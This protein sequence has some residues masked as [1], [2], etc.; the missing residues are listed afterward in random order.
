MSARRLL[1]A[2]V[3]VGTL[4][5]AGVLPAP[6][7][8]ACIYNPPLVSPPG[9]TV[10]TT[11]TI[12]GAADPGTTCNSSVILSGFG[13]GTNN[14]VNLFNK[15]QG[16]G[17]TG[18]GLVNDPSGQNEVIVGSFI[19]IQFVNPLPGMRSIQAN[20]VTDGET[21][22]LLGTNTPGSLAGAA[23]VVG[24]QTN[25]QSVI[26]FDPG[27][28]MFFDF[29]TT[30]PSGSNVLLARLDSPEGTVSTPEP[31]SL[32][33]LGAALVG[34]GVIRGRRRSSTSV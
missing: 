19:Q 26:N 22:T 6:S 28:F 11:T 30:T 7:A 3:L 14:P 33:I 17:E 18:F 4:G 27:T 32:A 5:A 25:N 34:L 2:T 31:T 24:I 12:A 21:W 23:T 15:N 10:G 20:S 29:T 13:P 1:T 8:D 9:T 16:A